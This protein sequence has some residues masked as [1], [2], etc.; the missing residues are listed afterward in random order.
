MFKLKKKH[1]G[2]RSNIKFDYI[3]YL[4]SEIVTINTA[5][6]QI[7]I[8]IP[9]EN[10]VISLITSDLDLNFDVVHAATNS[11]WADIDDE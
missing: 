10:S 5:N 4:P 7:Y 3:R 6:F 8:N 2:N 1:E 9:R 11:R